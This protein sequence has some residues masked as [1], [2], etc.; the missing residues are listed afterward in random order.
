MCVTAATGRMRY[1]CSYMYTCTV[2]AG[3]LAVQISDK[4][5]KEGRVPA[6][7]MDIVSSHTQS[8]TRVQKMTR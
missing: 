3:D 5:D 8:L 6:F 1:V 2:L 7:D 4:I